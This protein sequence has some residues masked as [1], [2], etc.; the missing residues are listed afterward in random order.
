MKRVIEYLLV[1]TASM[2]FFAFYQFQ[3]DFLPGTD[4]YYHI[5]TAYVMRE[6]G[7][8]SDFKWAHLSLWREQFS[9]KEF[10]FH[11]YLIPFTYFKDL[12]FGAK[13]GTVMLA[14]I[15]SSSFYAILKLNKVKYAWFWFLLLFMSGSYFLYRTNVTRPQVL[16]IVLVLWTIH[17][18][19]N[20]KLIHLA[21]I[22]FIY[23]FSYT[24]YHLPFIFACIAYGH[25]LLFEKKNDWK[26]PVVALGAT[27]LGMLCSP[28]FPN[29]WELFY[30]Q[31]FYIPYMASGSGVNLFMGGEFGAMSTKS[32]LIAQVT[33]IIAFALAFF[34]AM[35]K[36]RKWNVPTRSLFLIALSLI[37]IT[38]FSKRF[39]E[40]S[41]PVTLLFCAFFFNAY[42]KD[43][44]L[45][46]RP[47]TLKKAGFGLL[48][49][50]LL[51]VLGYNSYY[52]TVGEF[53]GAREPGLKSAALYLQEH[54]D[55]NEL[56]YT[57]DWDDG[58]ELFFYNHKNRYLVFLDPNFMYYWNKE[59]WHRWND[60]S[61]GRLGKQT[62]DVLKDEFKVR[63][64]VATSNFSQLRNIINNDPRMEI[65][66]KS[67]GAFVFKLKS[68]EEIE[69]LE[70]ETNNTSES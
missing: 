14:S 29:N 5:K 31:N 33:V 53:R 44:E 59:I 41:V 24:A 66:H 38:C 11:V 70:E 37:W 22:C 23:T 2:L 49:I 47:F 1:F 18:V 27:I 10:L 19:I 9:D 17:F 51:S 35:Y 4:G 60:L 6:M 39:T 30:I 63:Y 7:F 65:V 20:R 15:G 48:G 58:P 21:V 54:T 61:S 62:Y 8:L 32:A 25:L 42:L 56:V 12:M 40:Y 43:I 50:I 34:M 26:L 55:E 36:P 52:N 16:S 45:P 68:E 13:L 69:E 46:I 28:F 64:G 3:S 67:P 57:G